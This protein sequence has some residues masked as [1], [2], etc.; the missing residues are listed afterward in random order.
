MTI[1][2]ALAK[3]TISVP[4]A[5]E[6]FY[7]LARQASYDAAK[8]G[9]IQTIRVGGRI[10]VPVAPLAQKLGLRSTIGTAA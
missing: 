6:L 2:E 7:G 9:D 5:G 4:E 8:R 3:A 10:V 1:D